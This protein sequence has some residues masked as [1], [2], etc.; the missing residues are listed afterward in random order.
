M[1]GVKL[2]PHVLKS[3]FDIEDLRKATIILDMKITKICD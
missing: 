3:Y 2:H 1:S